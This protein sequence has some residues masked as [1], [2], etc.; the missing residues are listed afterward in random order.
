VFDIEGLCADGE[1][2]RTELADFME[3]L[4]KEALR[5]EDKTRDSPGTARGP[6]LIR[7]PAPSGGARRESITRPTTSPEPDAVSE[8]I[9]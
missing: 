7:L 8:W 6:Q 4:E 2:A 3:S 5:F 9:A 1:R